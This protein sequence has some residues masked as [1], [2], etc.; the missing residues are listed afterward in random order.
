MKKCFERIR[1]VFIIIAL[2]LAIFGSETIKMQSFANEENKTSANAQNS[3]TSEA[4]TTQIELGS[5]ISLGKYNGKNIVWRCVGIDENGYLMLADNILDTLPYD[6]MTSDNSR[7][8]SH[9]RNY[10]RDTYGSNYW[11]D[12]NMR[13]WLNSTAAAG[14][15]KW[16]CGN[17]PKAGYVDGNAYDQKAGFLNDFSKAEIAAIKNVTQRSLVSHPEYNHGFYDGDGRSDLELNYNIDSVADNFNSAYGENST[18]KVFLP[19]VQQVNTVWKNFGNYYV[20][21]NEQGATWPYWLRT[22]VS[23]CNHDMRYVHS[24]GSVGRE[25]PQRSYIGVRPAFYLDADYYVTTSGNGSASNPYVGSAPDKIEDDYT[26]AEPEEDPNQAWDVSLDKQLRL[27]LGPN[28]S[29]DGKYST[30]TIPVYTIQKTRSDTENMVIL[31]CGEG[32]TKGQQQ[33]FIND[34]KK[35]WEGAMQYEPY[36]SYADRFNVYALCT[37]SESS[38][39]SGGS[40]FFDVVVGSNNSSS[41]STNMG[42][43]WK[44]HIFER[45][46]GPAFIEQIHD[47]HIPNNTEPDKMYWEDKDQYPPF[48]YVHNYINQFALLVNTSQNF[49][50]NYTNLPFGF[51]YFITPADSYRAPQTFAHEFGHGLLGLGDEYMPYVT[52]Q[53]DLTSLNVGCNVNPEQVKWK[54][55]LGFRKTYSCPSLSYGNAFNSSYECLMRDTNYQFCEVCK[56]QGY[57]RL[58]Q[59]VEGKSLYVADP[60][61]KKYTGSYSKPS[62]FADTTFNGYFNF[63]NS[64]N[65]VLLSGGDKNKFNTGMASEKIQL[66]TIIQN[67]SDATQR[68]VTMK[69]WI[70]RAD[71]SVATTRSG[72]KLE[73][74]QTFTIPVWSEKSKFWPKGALSYEGSNMNSGLENCELIYQIPSDAVLN[75]GD[76]VAFEVTDENGNVLANDNT[77]TRPYANVNIEY[78]FDD[79]SEIPNAPKAVIPLAVGSYVNWTT[80]PSLYGYALSRVEGLNQIVSGSGQTV[81]YYY[82]Y[83]K[84]TY[85]ISVTDCVAKKGED[86]VEYAH[87]GD[88]IKVTANTPPTGEVFDKWVITGIDTTGMDLTKPEI[89]FNMPAANVTFK[90]TYL[91]IEKFEIYVVDGTKDKSPAKAGETITITANPAPT[92]KVFDKW[93]CETA[94]VAIEFTNATS[95]KT[96]FVMPAA[97]IEIKAHFRDIEA[98]PSVEIKVVG[99]TGGG[100]YQQGDEVTITAD[101]KEG[102]VFK[103]WKDES[104][105]I[106]STDMNYKFEITGARTLTAVYDDIVPAPAPDN[107]TPDA[108]NEIKPANEG[109]SGGQIAGI[110]IG[111]L[112]LAGIG[113]FAIFWFAVKKKTFADLIAAIKVLFTKKK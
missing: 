85:T 54:K 39:S 60:E 30:P 95:A 81:T 82:T 73:T 28:Y 70:K 16:L 26:V 77:E 3:S 72:N 45:C 59:L 27:T 56:L 111:T 10:K 53:N 67:L 2:V 4:K 61:V 88:V 99:G 37:A 1:T 86:T 40:T 6:A 76:T 65:G 7:S 50:D 74:T 17:P 97:E 25:S 78:R 21:K 69:L 49:G 103:G 43:P 89:T 42:N 48:Y 44:N 19:D 20:G 33:K 32:Y 51:H 84:A 90:A 80:A 108:P 113:G 58:S 41:I 106:V 66:R 52:E 15:V 98:A 110:V 112:P 29:R 36:R 57:K 35:V 34:V 107:P 14:E 18:E 75:N 11:K 83:V 109:L 101:D 31:I 22:P 94:G 12:S 24:N 105:N 63:A 93:T 104:G 9:S 87:Y 8:K 38:F 47:A 100:T 55:L 5:Y 23:D 102:K 62:D 68:Y 46:I 92:G 71:G 91:T 96:T 64:R 13:S 79:G